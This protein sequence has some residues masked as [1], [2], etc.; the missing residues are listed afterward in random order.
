MA[1][2]ILLLF[3]IGFWSFVLEN[4]GKTAALRVVVTVALSTLL[5]VYVWC[6]A[7]SSVR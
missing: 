2:A 1:I 6:W 3:A 4:G 7:L 5:A